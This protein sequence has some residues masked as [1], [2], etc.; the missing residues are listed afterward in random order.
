MNAT[1]QVLFNQTEEA[2]F[3]S[4]VDEVMKVWASQSG[5]ANLNISVENGK[6]D[7]QLAFKLGLP[8]DAHLPPPQHNFNPPRFKS[9]A[10]KAKD[11]ARAAAHQKQQLQQS[12]EEPLISPVQDHQQLHHVAAPAPLNP[13]AVPAIPVTIESSH[14]P[15]QTTV[16]AESHH[17]AAAPVVEAV[18]ASNSSSPKLSQAASASLP[19]AATAVPHHKGTPA[20]QNQ[21]AAPAS[22]P[23]N[24]VNQTPTAASA[25]FPLQETPAKDKKNP[26]LVRKM[27][28]LLNKA[29]RLTENFSMHQKIAYSGCQR[30]IEDAY[31]KILTT[32]PLDFFEEKVYQTYKATARSF[33]VRMW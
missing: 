31:M 23:P 1:S 27:K 3:L 20:K 12:N 8:G 32:N 29:D 13:V 19:Q 30:E 15:F 18:P 22:P 9:P 21:S 33:G 25:S 11:K 6:V 28:L 10:R 2:F 4:C 7:L 14:A 24:Q 17:Q 26:E 16:P 5:Q